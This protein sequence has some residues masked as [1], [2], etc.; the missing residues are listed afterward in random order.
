MTEPLLVARDL[1]KHFPLRRGVLLSREQGPSMPSTASRFEIARGETLGLVGESGCGKST[2]AR[3]VTRLLEPTSGQVLYD[4]SRHHALVAPPAAT[5]APRA[6]DV[7]QDPYSSLN[8]RR[9]S[10]AIVGEPLRSR[11]SARSRA[12]RGGCAR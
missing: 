5:A 11:A 9:R 6:A 3:L 10:G 1:V 8:P 12:P 2:T 7:F 4:G